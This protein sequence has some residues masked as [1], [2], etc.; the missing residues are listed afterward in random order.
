MN[1]NDKHGDGGS[2]GSSGGGGDLHFNNA[3]PNMISLNPHEQTPYREH[4]EDQ[5]GRVTCSR[6]RR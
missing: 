3:F 5:E 1:E 6:L 2:G 4:P